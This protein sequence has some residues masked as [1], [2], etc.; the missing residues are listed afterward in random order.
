M[1]TKIKVEK[2]VELTTLL[3]DAGVSYW[4]DATVNGENDTE[5]DLIPCRMGERWMPVINIETGIIANWELG[6]SAA[7]HYKI[8]DDG[9]YYLQDNEGAT[10]LAKEG[11]VPNILD[12]YNDSFGDYIKLKINENGQIADWNNNPNIDDFFE[13]D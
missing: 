10:Q 6:K 7:V 11:Y 3:V 12:L 13:E 4:E 2:E 8:C 9:I 5:G 1:K